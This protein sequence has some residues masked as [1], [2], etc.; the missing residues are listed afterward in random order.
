MRQG[1]APPRSSNAT[2]AGKLILLH[3]YCADK[4]PFAT[5]PDDWTDALFYYRG[6]PVSMS[7]DEYAQFVCGPHFMC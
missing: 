1:V 6:E 5:Y 2:N 3:G 4:N 7:H